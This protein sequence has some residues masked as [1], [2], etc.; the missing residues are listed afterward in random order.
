MDS[1]DDKTSESRFAG[2][3]LGIRE[4]DGWEYASRENAT[5][6]VVIIA[7][8]RAGEIVLVEQHRIPVNAPVI[9]LPAGLVGDEGDPDEPLARAAERELWEETGYRA[10]RM[11]L[12]AQC[13]SSAG[14]SD[15]MLSIF[16]AE[17]AVREGAGGGDD[18]EDIIV[19]TVPLGDVDR[20]LAEALA[21]G[22]AFDP[23][24]HMGLYWLARRPDLTGSLPAAKGSP[25]TR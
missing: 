19:H 11:T 20:W 16:L 3:Y 9:E 6:V 4:R 15:E 17:D 23:K 25:G 12:V 24:V 13:P 22:R 18:S 10:E 5:G 14:M 2:R 1:A 7:V 8:T 21:R